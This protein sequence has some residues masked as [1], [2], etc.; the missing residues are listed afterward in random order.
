MTQRVQPA[1]AGQ[2]L[3]A[4][5]TDVLAGLAANTGAQEFVAPFSLAEC[6][7]GAGDGNIGRLRLVF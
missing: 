5:E 3:N 7:A 6:F 2:W 4:R 1:T